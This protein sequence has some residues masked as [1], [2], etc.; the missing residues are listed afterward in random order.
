MTTQHQQGVRLPWWVVL[1]VLLGAL[2]LCAGAFIALL[3]PAMLVSSSDTING[4][5]HVYAGY[6]ASRNL[7]LAFILVSALTLQARRSLGALMVLIALVQALD[8]CMDCAEGRWMIAP[9]VV[10]FAVAFLFGAARVS[11]NPFWRR[12]AWD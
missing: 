10:V 8:A 7:A 6:L 5:V 3:H 2:L 11:G 12:S 4:A 1:E 9:G